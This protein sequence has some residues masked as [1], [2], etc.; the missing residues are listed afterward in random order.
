M[1]NNGTVINVS[2]ACIVI[3]HKSAITE[4]ILTYD[5]NARDIADTMVAHWS[6]SHFKF[7]KLKFYISLF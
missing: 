4:V 5:L 2:S 7:C 1:A 3:L 6:Q